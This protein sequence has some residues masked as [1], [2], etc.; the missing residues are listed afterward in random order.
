VILIYILY[1]RK[2]DYMKKEMALPKKKGGDVFLEEST[3]GFPIA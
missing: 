1:Q 2:Y 3:I